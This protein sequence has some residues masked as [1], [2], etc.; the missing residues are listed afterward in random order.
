MLPVRYVM[1]L[2]AMLI[3]GAAI[4]F[5]AAA[6]IYVMESTVSAVRVGSAIDMGETLTIPAGSL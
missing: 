3:A 2:A 6:Q 5:P 4:S 1:A